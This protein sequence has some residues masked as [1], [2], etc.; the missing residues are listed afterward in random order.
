MFLTFK[1]LVLNTIYAAA[2]PHN[3]RKHFAAKKTA[4]EYRRFI[5]VLREYEFRILFVAAIYGQPCFVVSVLY[6][7][8]EAIY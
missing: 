5:A 3:R 1:G 2:Y 4:S 7:P 8:H 6:L